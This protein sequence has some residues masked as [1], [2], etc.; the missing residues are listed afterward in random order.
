MNTHHG[1]PRSR[2]D[3]Y[4]LQARHRLRL[5]LLSQ[6]TAALLLVLALITL[7]AAFALPRA[8]FSG[9]AALIA[10]VIVAI[11]IC[12][13]A[14]LFVL[15]WRALHRDE[16]SA[17]LER[18][19][20]A[21]GGRVQT[22]LQERR[23]QASSI[24]LD[25][26]ADD[27]VRLADSQP[28]EQSIPSRRLWMPA[29]FA[30]IALAG[31]ITLMTTAGSLGDGTRQLW[32]GKLPTA[33]RLA[34]A[35]GGIAVRPGDTKVRRNQDLPISAVVAGGSSEAHVHVRFGQ[36]DIGNGAGE[37]EVTPMDSDSNGNHTFTL[38]AVRDAARYYITSGNLR[39]AEHKIEVV[40]LPRIENMRL[41]YQYPKWTG[42]PQQVEDGGGDIRGVAE[43]RVTLQLTADKPI[44]SP[45]LIVNGDE[46]ALTQSNLTTHGT[47][48]IKAAGNY[49]I[50]TRIDNEI[51]PLTEDFNIDVVID[52]KPEVQIIKPGK[53]FRATAI[54]EVPVRVKAQDDFK[55]EAL[56]L[57]YSV[58]GS[59]WRNEKL[60][61]GSRDIQAA[62][63][64]RLEE[65]QQPQSGEAALLTP[66]DLV[67]YYMLAR[68]YHHSVQTELFLIQ[69][70]PFEQ[71]FTQSQA[72]A[73]SGGGGGE[74]D[75]QISQ[76]QR[77]LLLATWNLQR[78]KTKEGRAAERD[79]QRDQDN[80]AMLSEVQ[81]TLGDQTQT[82][83]LRAKARQLT[84][85]DPNVAEFV[86]SLEEAEKSMRPAA[87]ALANHDLETAVQH[88]QKALQQLLRA[89]S[90]FR[91]IQ[92]AMGSQRGGGGG[93]QAGRDVSEM[94]ELEMD[95]A[96]NQY[97]TQPQMTA[98]QRGQSE[99]DALRR[100][101]E[102]AK[103]QEQLARDATRNTPTEAQ[104]WQQE[105]LRR[106][107]EQLRQ[108]LEQLAQQSNSQSSNQR[109]TSGQTSGQQSGQASNQ[110]SPS[111]AAAQ[112]A[113][114]LDQAL[115]DMQARNDDPSKGAAR[116][117][118]Q[119]NRA[120]EQL[121]RGQQR[122]ASER[123]E[124]LARTARELSDKQRESEQALRDSVAPP[125]PIGIAR[126]GVTRN[127]LDAE[128]AQLLAE[129]KRDIRA[130]LE[131]LEQQMRDTQQ[132]TK[133]TPRA[134]Q[135]IGQAA[136]DLNESGTA[137]R[138]E[139]S[140]FDIERGRGVQA[141]SREGLISDSIEQ[142]KQS[143]EEA[144]STAT[145]ESNEQGERKRAAGAEDLLAEVGEL[146]RTLERAQQQVAQNNNQAG[147]DA[148]NAA[149][150]SAANT[151]Q[152]GGR[153][154]GAGGGRFTSRNGNTF[155]PAS[156]NNSLTNPATLRQ[157]AQL[158]GQRLQQLR[159][160]LANGTLPDTDL[161][162]VRELEGHL[163]RT[164]GDPM[165]SEYQRMI[166]LLNQLEL[167]ALQKHRANSTD[168][169]T[170]S[171]DNNDDAS[172]YRENVAEYYR[173]LG[174]TSK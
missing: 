23:K 135:R 12:A 123:F 63:L 99:D 31:L 37:W 28:L 30:L 58:N 60:P 119:L 147:R 41:T 43:T 159:E 158:S 46:S 98:Q 27:A 167:S 1:S 149:G 97:E 113:K 146:R 62:A 42:L 133:R 141:A 87:E 117:S 79:V 2:L 35:A 105:Q 120:R 121:E 90:I 85:S 109:N 48:T 92:V 67:S 26:L 126:P 153:E 38:Y 157:Q 162:A 70:Q 29:A 47:V 170:R 55:V 74:E 22:Y 165:S 143:L 156:F 136:R 75:G 129:T 168:N 72:N 151:Q 137:R 54:E 17:A 116:A 102:L 25:L 40:D 127:A 115:R 78:N 163:R 164:N 5:A 49:R 82:L 94:T 77:E 11:A 13:V 36:D 148:A 89:E 150:T 9:T 138:L 32:L 106:E 57:H 8:G 169:P 142:L 95:L 111:S 14:L 56:E 64:L 50:A 61:A 6:S 122:D 10:R 88:E 34:I 21:Q 20:P 118:E 96:K 81:V 33:N 173:R 172:E 132:N 108:Q 68:D 71:R 91:D 110:S 80:A 152:G 144:A 86:K 101:R 107:A 114:Q 52:E 124:N 4:L 154:G 59:E 104:R 93:G 145:T 84:E 83:A 166:T 44:D 131:R 73:G 128:K 100:L 155:D 66:G 112:A 65:M 103:R 139:R 130:D 53:D 51:V 134:N 15:R 3:D 7:I 125:L 39:S 16:S 76:R 45:L 174:E 160:Q 24:L 19:L 140:A 69:V 161:R 171:V 18:A